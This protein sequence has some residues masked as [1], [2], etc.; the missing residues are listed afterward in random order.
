MHHRTHVDTQG[1]NTPFD[2]SQTAAAH[3][4]NCLGFPSLLSSN[5]GTPCSFTVTDCDGLAECY[6][7]REGTSERTNNTTK[8]ML[9]RL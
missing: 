8:A 9:R 3:G 2:V 7:T 4:I 1:F 5:S 6:E